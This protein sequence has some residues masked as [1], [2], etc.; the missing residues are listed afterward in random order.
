MTSLLQI[1][2]VNAATKVVQYVRIGRASEDGLD[3]IA[4]AGNILMAIVC[5]HH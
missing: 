3:Q 1:E 4:L 5:C 2:T